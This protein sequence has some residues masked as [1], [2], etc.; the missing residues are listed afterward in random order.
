[1]FWL[2]QW[3]YLLG[4]KESF[5]KAIGT[6]GQRWTTGLMWDNDLCET[7]D[8]LSVKQSINRVYILFCWGLQHRICSAP[9]R[10][11]HGH[12]SPEI[13]L[14]TRGRERSQLRWLG[15]LQFPH[16]RS[17]PRLCRATACHWT[18]VRHSNHHGH[19]QPSQHTSWR[20]FHFHLQSC[21]ES[22]SSAGWNVQ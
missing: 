18:R 5:S 4:G 10:G 9:G 21:R 3:L 19:V 12:A 14:Q 11:N 16:P 7:T 2:S 20:S 15:P 6:G 1:M 17:L 13:N 8:R 22:S